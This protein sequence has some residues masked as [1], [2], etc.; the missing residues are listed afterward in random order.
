MIITYPTQYGGFESD[1]HNLVYFPINKNAHTWAEKFFEKNFNM[2]KKIIKTTEN[3][4]SILKDK[5]S[6]VI[7]RDPL[8]RWLSGITQYLIDSPTLELL[9]NSLFQQAIKDA[10][11]FDNHTGLQIVNLLGIDTDKTIFF[12]CDKHLEDNMYEFSRLWFGKISVSVGQHQVLTQNPDKV[13]IYN[14]IKEIVKNDSLLIKRIRDFYAPDYKIFS[15]VKFFNQ[16]NISFY[17]NLKEVY[18]KGN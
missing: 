4:E 10:L 11:C 6:I 7:L 5:I 15:E 2:D 18:A 13:I 3:S 1:D 12:N 14:K 16:Q 8:L 17:K 9:D